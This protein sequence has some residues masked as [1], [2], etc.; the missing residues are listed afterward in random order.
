MILKLT[1]KSHFKFFKSL[2]KIKNLKKI[3]LKK[4]FIFLLSMELY[5]DNCIFKL[6]F[7]KKT[8]LKVNLL[9][10]PM[11][12]KKFFNQIFNETYIFKFFFY[13]SLE[14][15]ILFENIILFF[16]FLNKQVSSIGTNLLT[17]KKFSLILRTKK[18]NFF[19]L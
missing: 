17:K 6:F 13:V 3:F 2:K 14:N 15:K 18:A 1:L 9:K 12:Y 19:S 10:S 4:I 8:L 11:R 16:K 5:L 7:F